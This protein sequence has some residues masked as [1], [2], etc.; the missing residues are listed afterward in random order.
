MDKGLWAALGALAG[1]PFG[2]PLLGAGAGL[3]ASNLFGGN[4][5]QQSWNAQP[6]PYQPPPP[7]P[8]A[9]T[10]GIGEAGMTP[11]QLKMI[12]PRTQVSQA[13]L[14]SKMR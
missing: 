4:D 1:L 12:N 5:E 8:P 13:L 9:N 3:M 2:G 6:P 7:P 10:H 14:K 11:E